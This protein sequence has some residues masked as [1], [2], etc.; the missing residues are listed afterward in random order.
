[1][2]KKI[3]VLVCAILA[4]ISVAGCG[5]S[6][7]ANSGKKVLRMAAQDPQVPLDPQKHTYSHLL[8]ISDQILEPLIIAGDGGQL[9]PLL[10]AEMPQLKDDKK[11]YSFTLK[12][13][14][15][16]HNGE[17]LKSSDVKYSFM[18]LLTE[19]KMGNLID[20]IQGADK[21]E[22]K[23]SNDLEGFKIIDDTH[24]EITLTG[25]YVPFLAAIATDYVVIYPEQACKAAGND[26][27]IKTLIGTGPFKLEA[28]NQ[29]T[30]VILVKNENY[31]GVAPKLDEVDFKFIQDPN[32]QVME[33]QKGNVDL[34]Q[35]DSAL[36]PTFANNEELKK[37]MH[38]FSPYGLVFLTMNT[39]KIS[40]PKVREALSYA[41]DRN[42][43]CQDLLYGTAT[44]AKTFIPKG[45]L[46]YDEGAA[47]YAYNPEKAKQLLA[48]AGYPDGIDLVAQDNTK[49]PTYSKLLVAIQ[50]QAKAAGIRITINQVD[51]AAWAD[52]KH[53][54]KMTMAV[55]NWYI[56]Y[57]DPDGMIYQTMSEKLTKQNSNFYADPIFNNLLNTARATLDSSQRE[58][59]YKQADQILTRKDYAAI[60]ICNETMFYLAKSYVKGFNVD[61]SYR[62][63]FGTTDIQK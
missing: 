33:Y 44:P 30:S 52:M 21:L 3:L 39:Q 46:G 48:E 14:V 25:P 24:F 29:G 36:Y 51:N 11:T 55:S 45:L 12:S 4:L 50:E 63:Y 17:I 9:K 18:R 32:T 23:E 43:I 58:A 54:G 16:F 7:T 49:Y 38:S 40:D 57:V 6:D 2:Q 53:S 8:K 56:D 10:L 27:G 61:S 13:G 15:K 42:A 47:E 35:L 28:Y 60:P 20:M 26:W 41:I 59:M 19:G 37:D 31:H 5:N 22:K 62:Y 34:L 1:M